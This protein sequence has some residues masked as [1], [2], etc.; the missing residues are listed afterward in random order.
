[1]KS[2]W[3]SLGILCWA[4]VAAADVLPG[5]SPQRPIT[6]APPKATANRDPVALA[7]RSPVIA[8]Q[9]AEAKGDET[10]VQVALGGQCGFA[11]CS[12]STLV[13]F[14]FRSRGANTMTQSVLA[15]VNCPP[16]QSVECQVQPAEVRPSTPSTPP[17]SGK[18][19]QQR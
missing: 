17:V 5:P 6:P 16:V 1:M 18:P 15:L 11:G 12:Q 13:A 8:K 4:T 2:H 7:R 10:A 19:L 3:L 9:L 14:T